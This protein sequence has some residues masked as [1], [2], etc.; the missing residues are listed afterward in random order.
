MYISK[1]TVMK[2]DRVL[3]EAGLKYSLNLS[4]FEDW[5][6]IEELTSDYTAILNIVLD[7]PIVKQYGGRSLADRM[8][9]SAAAEIP[10]GFS[11]CMHEYLKNTRGGG[12]C[13]ALETGGEGVVEDVLREALDAV[14]ASAHSEKTLECFYADYPG[15]FTVWSSQKYFYRAGEIGGMG[16]DW[17]E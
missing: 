13:I 11:S 8:G 3:Q 12:M 1:E 5:H 2:A 9:V 10:P 17:S 6:L 15:C 4:L 16:L 7:L 14:E